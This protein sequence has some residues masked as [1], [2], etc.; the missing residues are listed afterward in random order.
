VG[1]QTLD[2]INQNLGI[3][4]KLM[5]YFSIILI[6]CIFSVTVYSE[7]NK[8]V[9]AVEG[10]ARIDFG[11]YSAKERKEAFY[12]IINKGD[13][14][15]RI[16]MIRKTC[17]CA[18]AEID[19]KEIKPGEFGILKAVVLGDSIYGGYSKNIYVSSNDLK[20]RFLVL[21]F[22]GKAIPI[23]KI[24]PKAIIY[25]GHLPAEKEWKQE[26]LLEATESGVKL[27]KPVI[28]SDTHVKAVLTKKSDTLF[29][30]IIAIIPEKGKT[31]FK[32]TAKI[33]IA[34][35]EGWKAPE[36]LIVGKIQ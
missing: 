20:Q 36:I 18:V 35:P 2:I 28:K 3:G 25:A 29:Q 10:N 11:T 33:P 27:G 6:C 15:L 19:R 26:F 24:K 13:A 12:K 34:E 16:G 21:N 14:L 8:P 1:I 7:G 22:S 31:A 32:C 17:G 4:T 30:L 9:I 23:L 5:K